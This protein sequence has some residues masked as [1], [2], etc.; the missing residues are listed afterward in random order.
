MGTR[1]QDTTIFESIL[2]DFAG[3]VKQVMRPIE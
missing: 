2:I 1:E 3:D